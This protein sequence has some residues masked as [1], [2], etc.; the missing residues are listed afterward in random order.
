MSDLQALIDTV[1]S[2]I[3]DCRHL[4]GSEDLA[5]LDI[6]LTSLIS[7]SSQVGNFLD[8]ILVTRQRQV[9]EEVVAELRQLHLCLNQLCLQ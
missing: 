3:A 1:S 2:V 5:Q 8:E 7:T 6:I 9:D 4:S